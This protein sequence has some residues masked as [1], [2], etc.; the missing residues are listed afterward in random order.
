MCQGK[1]SVSVRQ[2]YE[3]MLPQ[4]PEKMQGLID[5]FDLALSHPDENVLD[6]LA[7]AASA[8]LS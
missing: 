2:R 6:S 1:M 4:A 7:R 8:Y 5:N 3:S